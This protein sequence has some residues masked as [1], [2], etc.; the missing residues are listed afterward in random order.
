[1]TKWKYLKGSEKDFEVA[2]EWSMQ[3]LRE[4]GTENIGYDE[5]IN[6]KQMVGD[7]LL[8]P[9]LHGHDGN[10]YR[11]TIDDVNSLSNVEI[12]AQRE[13]VTDEDDLNECIGAAE[14]DMVNNPPHYQSDNGVEC[15]DAIRASLGRDGFIAYCQG[16]IMK[17][18][19]RNQ[20]KGAQTQDIQK[21]IWYA[22]KIIEEVNK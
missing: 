19:W 16:N 1:M 6:G 12:I 18:T 20:S 5:N 21:A 3:V 2:P 22:N 14:V 8:W 11:L 7:R 17:Y 10:P 13:P 9:D 4:I 15:I